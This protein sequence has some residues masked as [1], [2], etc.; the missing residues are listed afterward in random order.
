MFVW[1]LMELTLILL[2]IILFTHCPEM[3][4]LSSSWL[5][6][7]YF[8]DLIWFNKLSN[9][10][11]AVTIFKHVWS[12]YPVYMNVF[13]SSS[14]LCKIIITICNCLV[15]N[16]KCDIKQISFPNTISDFFV[17]THT[18]SSKVGYDTLGNSK[19]YKGPTRDVC[20]L[21]SS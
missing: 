14:K 21:S 10:N 15:Y 18:C 11:Y 4:W 19:W 2:C 7:T 17:H 3:T 13:H 20:C 5:N 6:N 9:V 1:F 16:F 12:Y 8:L